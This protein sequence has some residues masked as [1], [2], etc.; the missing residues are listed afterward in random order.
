MC[1]TAACISAACMHLSPSPPSTQTLAAIVALFLA[2]RAVVPT[3]CPHP[4]PF[5][6]FCSFYPFCPLCPFCL[7]FSL[8]P[9]R[10]N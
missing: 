1:T 9:N 6:P 7:P 8:D 5:Y 3:S 2:P 4:C 10:P